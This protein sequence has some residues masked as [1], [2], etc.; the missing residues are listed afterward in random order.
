MFC[1]PEPERRRLVRD[2]V[3]N[4]LVSASESEQ[5]V[6]EEPETRSFS[7]EVSDSGGRVICK[8]K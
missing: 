1:G 5:K 3:E 4:F 7:K 6:R 2:A 8:V